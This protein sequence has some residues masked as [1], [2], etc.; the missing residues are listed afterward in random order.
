M[1]IPI[2]EIQAFKKINLNNI[3]KEGEFY[4]KGMSSRN[5]HDQRECQAETFMTRGTSCDNIVC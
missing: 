4:V 2:M 5:F 3:T 1:Q